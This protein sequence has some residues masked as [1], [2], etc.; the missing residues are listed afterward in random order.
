MDV[1]PSGR[2]RLFDRDRAVRDAAHLFWRHGFSGTSTRV[3]TAALGIS[4]SSLYAAFGSKAGLFAE[5]VHMHARRY[6]AIYERA[7]SEA[8]LGH[9]VDR[10]LVDSVHEFTRVGDDHVGCLTTSA[11]MADAPDTLDVRTFV[12]ERQRADKRL[13][14][15]RVE[16]AVLDGEVLG[17]VDAAAFTDLV[18]TLWHGLSVRASLGAGRTEL[19]ASVRLAHALIA[20]TLRAQG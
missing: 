13:L 4:S 16:R 3:L 9:V 15:E 8:D 19:L 14:R 7:V 6:T 11:A 18:Q 2:P 10:L 1:R 5:A 20:G 17:D 12:D